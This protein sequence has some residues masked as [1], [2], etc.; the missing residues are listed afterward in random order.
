MSQKLSI[1]QLA[2]K[3]PH[4]NGIGTFTALFTKF[5]LDIILY[6]KDIVIPVTGRG[7]R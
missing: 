4:F 3:A 5:P 2:K 7:G 1:S 6:K